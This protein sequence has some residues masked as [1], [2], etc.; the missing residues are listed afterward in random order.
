MCHH[1]EISFSWKSWS[2]LKPPQIPQPRGN[3]CWYLVHR[4]SDFPVWIYIHI[5]TFFKLSSITQKHNMEIFPHKYLGTTSSS[6]MATQLSTVWRHHNLS[7]AFV[8]DIEINPL[9]CAIW[10][11]QAWTPCFIIPLDS[12]SEMRLHVKEYAVSRF[13]IL[14]ATFSTR[15]ATSVT[16][17][18]SSVK[19]R[20]QLCEGGQYKC[21]DSP[22]HSAQSRDPIQKSLRVSAH[23][24]S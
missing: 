11:M 4:H 16:F 3:E 21:L 24:T 12:F 22:H 19:A 9:W 2:E 15:E 23:E 1:C 6:F 17:P 13:L 8:I 14:K 10:T 18:I 5:H 7:S 20:D